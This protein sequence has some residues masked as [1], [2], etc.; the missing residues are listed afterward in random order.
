MKTVRINI[1]L[2]P[3]RQRV[4]LILRALPQEL[5]L[6]AINTGVN[7]D[8]DI[9]YCC[10]MLS[11]LVI[12]QREQSLAREFF[13]RDQ[14]AGK[15]DGMERAFRGSS[16]NGVTNWLAVQFQTGVRPPTIA[17]KLHA[18]ETNDLNQL[19]EAATRLKLLSR[20]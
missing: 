14:K 10:E 20:L 13:H 6:A 15:D 5:S 11:H 9:D 12:D 4:S 3:Q 1:R 18:A 7:A 2:Y 19:V 17:A 8:S 16:P